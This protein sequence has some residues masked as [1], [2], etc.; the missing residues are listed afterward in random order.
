MGVWAFVTGRVM[1]VR[2]G[3]DA[4]L[5]TVRALYLDV[6]VPLHNTTNLQKWT[7]L[8]RD[9]GTSTAQAV[10]IQDAQES[11]DPELRMNCKRWASPK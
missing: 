2:I 3:E 7:E 1:I 9:T 10:D 6:T 4:G 5:I 11:T 8:C